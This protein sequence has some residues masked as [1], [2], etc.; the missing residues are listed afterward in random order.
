MDKLPDNWELKTLSEVGY[1]I[2]SGNPD[3]TEKEYWNGNI[4]G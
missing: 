3:T 4:H 1:I 2:G